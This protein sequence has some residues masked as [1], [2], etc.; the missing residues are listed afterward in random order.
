MICLFPGCKE[1]EAGFLSLVLPFLSPQDDL[2]SLTSI[3]KN[4]LCKRKKIPVRSVQHKRI[5]SMLKHLHIV[6]DHR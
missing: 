3:I 4:I 1:G 6:N 2:G 5:I